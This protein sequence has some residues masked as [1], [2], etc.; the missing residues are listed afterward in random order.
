MLALLGGGFIL[1]GLS[2]EVCPYAHLSVYIAAQNR[3][4]GHAQRYP[5]AHGGGS[6]HI[7]IILS[8]DKALNRPDTFALLTF[9]T[10]HQEAL[11]GT[12][13]RAGEVHIDRHIKAANAHHITGE[14]GEALAHAGRL[15][16]IGG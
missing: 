2:G 1:V 4:F 3:H 11:D 6:L 13:G 14:Q 5:Q 9:H 12:G 16:R 7:G 15:Q 10:G 8:L